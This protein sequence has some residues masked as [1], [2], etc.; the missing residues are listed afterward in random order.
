MIYYR[1]R[2]VSAAET[3]RHAQSQSNAHTHKHVQPDAAGKV[4][5]TGP[6][7]EPVE[8]PVQ[9]SKVQPGSDRGLTGIN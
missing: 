1:V 5:K 2:Y 6:D 4:I 8:L 7:V 9:G 3:L